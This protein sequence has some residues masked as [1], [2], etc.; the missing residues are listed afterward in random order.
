MKRIPVVSR[1]YKVMLRP[2]RF[3]GRESA[4]LDAAR[5][6][7]DDFTNAIAHRVIATTGS[8]DRIRKGVSSSSSIPTPAS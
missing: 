2:S 4:L 8:L 1:E 3:S 7:W 6:F 5:M